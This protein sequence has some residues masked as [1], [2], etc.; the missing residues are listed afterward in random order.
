MELRQPPQV[1][2]LDTRPTGGD[3][4]ARILMAANL[5][6]VLGLV[7][8]LLFWAPGSAAPWRSG[9][10]DL[11]QLRQVASKLKAAGALDEAAELYEDYLQRATDVPAESRARIAFSLGTTYLDRGR[12]EQALRWFYEAETLGE[13]A[14]SPSLS[15]EVGRKIVHSLER[16]GRYQAARAALESQVALPSGENRPSGEDGAPDSDPVRRDDA[17][18]PIAARLG[19]REIRRSEVEA[20]LDALPPQMAEAFNGGEQRADFLRQYVAEQLMYRKAQKLEYDKD[21]EVRRQV[22]NLMRQLVIS[23]FVEQEVVSRAFGDDEGSIAEADLETWYRANRERYGDKE[24]AEARPQVAQDYRRD[25]VQRAYDAMIET[26]L[27]G[28]D[29]ELFPRAMTGATT[30]GGTPPGGTPSTKAPQPATDSP[31]SDSPGATP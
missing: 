18:D 5:A 11:D 15:Q 16:L 27:A 20:A 9:D 7:A 29:V 12:Y 26:E 24:F 14:L 22:E 17:A 10:G 1:D 6:A 4:I 30:T 25:K 31:A 21:P 2:D 8:L 3:R 23:R 19:E 13:G 28:E